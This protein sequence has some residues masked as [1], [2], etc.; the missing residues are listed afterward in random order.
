MAI[1]QLT[2]PIINPI[3]AFDA[4]RDNLVTFVVIGGTQVIANRLVI[5][6]NET[7]TIIYNK[8]K[9]TMKLEHTIPADTLGNGGY[10]NAVVYTI[11][12]AGNESD[13]STPVPFYCYSQP[14]LTISNIPTTETIG[15]GTYT[16]IGD[17]SQPEGEIL[18]SYQFTLYDSNKDILSQTPLIYYI[19]DSSLSYTFV[20]MSNDTA[21]Y[22]SISGET[23]NGT[24]ITSGL[25]YFTVRYLQPASFAICDLVNDCENGYIQISSNIVAIDGKSN[26]EPP[27]YIDDKE[28]DLRDPD[29]WVE[30]DEGFNIKDDFTMRVWGRDFNPYEN[31]ITLTNKENQN[32]SPN[33]IELKWMIGDIL[34]VLPEYVSVKGENVNVKNSEADS[35]KNLDIGGNSNQKTADEIDYGK[36]TS[37]TIVNDE[38]EEQGGKIKTI[39]HSEPLNINIYGNQYQF[40]QQGSSTEVEGESIYLSDVDAGKPADLIIKGNNYQET[41]EGY[42]LLDVNNNIASLSGLIYSDGIFT[43]ETITSQTV[44]NLWLRFKDTIAVN[45]TQNYYISFE[46]RIK[47]GTGDFSNNINDGTYSYTVV[48]KPTLSS[49]FQKYIVSHKYTESQE[50]SIKQILFQI[51]ENSNNLVIEIQNIMFGAKSEP[52]E[53]YGASPS[54]DYPSEVE[55]VGSNINLF[56]K[57][58]AIIING[59][60][61]DT[62]NQFVLSN[63]NNN[64]TIALKCKKDTTYTVSKKYGNRFNVFTYNELL[65]EEKTYSINNLVRGTNQ[66]STEPASQTI[67]TGD[68]EYLYVHIFDN[69][70]YFNLQNVL[71][72]IKIEEGSVATSYSPYNEGSVKI[73]VKNRNLLKIPFEKSGSS[74][75]LTWVVNDDGTIVLNGT[76]TASAHITANNVKINAK[77]G[78]TVTL[79]AKGLENIF[80]LGYKNIITGNDILTI[81]PSQPSNTITLTENDLQLANRLDVYIQSGKTFNNQTLKIMLEE[82]T[83]VTSYVESQEQ[84]FVM[85]IQ[86]EILKGDYINVD[87][88][89]ETHIMKKLVLQ[90]TETIDRWTVVGNTMTEWRFVISAKGILRTSSTTEI[91]NIICNKLKTTSAKNTYNKETG[92]SGEANS[93]VMIIYIEECKTMT[94]SEFNAYLKQQYDAGNPIIVYYQLATPISLPLTSEQ[95]EIQSQLTNVTLYQGVTNITNESSYP[96]IM[97]LNY[98][99]VREMPSPNY[100]SEIQTVGD[101]I[102]LL[103]D[104]LTLYQGNYDESGNFFEN[105]DR[106]IKDF[107]ELDAGQ[108]ILWSK[109]NNWI[110]VLIYNENKVLEKDLQSGANKKE[111]TFELVSKGYIRFAFYPIVDSLT[112]FK[113]EKGSVATP[114]SPYNQGSVEVNV[115]NKNLLN[116][117]DIEETEK[118]GVTYSIKNGVLTLNGTATVGIQLTFLR[119]IHIK[120]GKYTHSVNYIKNGLFFSF[121]NLAYTMLNGYLGNK[122]ITFE[123]TEDK[124]FS[125][126]FLFIS[127]NTVLDNVKLD[128][129]LEE[130]S[131][132]SDFVPHQSQSIIMPIQQ[133]MLTDDY[134]SGSEYHTWGKSILTGDENIGIDGVHQG[135][136]QFSV[137]VKSQYVYDN[138]IRALSNYFN[139]VGFINSWKVDNS[140]TT[141]VNGNIRFMTSK[142]AT[143]ADF[144]LFLK[145]KYDEGNPVVAYYKLATPTNISLTTEQKTIQNQLD[146][147]Y[148]YT[149][150][151]HINTDEGLAILKALTPA[152][153][154]PSRQSKIYSVGERKNLID[155]P[156]FNILLNDEYGTAT[157][158]NLVLKPN[159]TYTLSFDYDIHETST[160][161]YYSIG[162]GLNSY[163]QDIKANIVYQNITT[164]KNSAT[165]TVPND[166]PAN[167]YLWIKFGHT[168]IIANANVDIKNVQFEIGKTATKYQSPNLYNIYPTVS[169]KNLY[170]YNNP[171]YV[172]QNNISYNLIGGGYNI[173][174]TAVNQSASLILGI[175][176]IL[177]PGDTYAISFESS[178]QLSGYNLYITD[179]E[180]EEPTAEIIINNGVFTAPEG[181]YDLQLSFNVDSSSLDNFLEIWNIQIEANDVISEYETYGSNNS[182]IVLSEPI[183][184]LGERRDLICL[185][186]PNIINPETQSATVKGNT[187]Y[188]LSQKGSIK[189]YIWYY[190]EEGNLITFVDPEGQEASGAVGINGQFTT[191]K[192]CVK[193][194]ITKS[195]NPKAGDVNSDELISNQVIISKGSSEIPYYPYIT[196][197]SVI[198]YIKKVT[199]NGT[200]NWNLQ[201][202]NSYGI[203]NFNYKTGQSVVEVKFNVLSNYFKTQTTFVS[204]TAKEGIFMQWSNEFFIRIKSNRASTVD[205]FKSFLKSKYDKGNPV[206][207]YYILSEPVVEELSTDNISALQ[208]LKTYLP[209][210]NVFTNNNILATSSFDYV[211]GYT[212][213]QTENAY[214]L[215]K[216]WNSNTMPYVIHSNFIDIPKDINKVFIWMRRKN[217]IFDLKIEDLGDYGENDNPTDV[218]KPVV[219]IEINPDKVTSTQIPVTATSVDETGLRTVRFSK[220]N[221]ES[222]DEVIPV[223]GLSSINSYAFSNLNPNTVYP[224][225]VEAI[226]LAGNIGGIT[227]NVSTK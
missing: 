138:I 187:V 4:S 84:S 14:T 140:I 191:H 178:G 115:V 77:E 212:E 176:N 177:N 130:G 200:E 60:I 155:V 30:W 190:N 227:Q 148:T 37:I 157:K 78:A 31:I 109:N 33:K 93:D 183:R 202:I 11:D 136:T 135:I 29:S 154:S 54:P 216:C 98:N 82:G 108:Y 186:S 205:E 96:A 53:Q 32:G 174:P 175:K 129:Q 34:K 68:D 48:Q 215:L 24:K 105:N 74:N 111:V 83:T 147:S 211:D 188:Y 207:V 90:G 226:D 75:G 6:D 56:D 62:S 9:S 85:P 59:Y 12:S 142:Y 197:P 218:T 219:S 7:G 99:I 86:Q 113:L 121:D 195:N 210:S 66:E 162:Y 204:E 52:Y 44:R 58:N 220:N 50:K 19:T 119:N 198:R 153:P 8:T 159:Y 81:T 199:L 65:Q 122:T 22:I 125:T 150:I 51:K 158:T 91:A 221:G 144:K 21:Y 103:D 172:K 35:I 201:S 223:D 79:S 16:F 152:I 149:P 42:N 217:N 139:G 124:V 163:E 1:Q 67:S 184:G 127:Q 141:S 18:N 208:S 118:S 36:D 137:F 167:N 128:L 164:G 80:N 20:G 133:E 151:T 171:L 117:V 194:T 72:T 112:D 107:I 27:I 71:N 15:N 126:Y 206:E 222:W 214:V 193:I 160:D 2:Q 123:L 43:S 61:R 203:A 161:I 76:T 120:K 170:D 225:R 25:V 165:I 45:T 28:V 102:N 47:S 185:D 97:N 181:L 116:L 55:T 94:I 57:D 101:N 132:A 166:I 10:Y 70:N 5:S 131:T 95:Q 100:P 38:Q 114:Y 64:R 143:V 40:T 63:S 179:K 169:G 17:Y 196:K 180:S 110:H 39:P 189:Y 156:D 88:K 146:N 73:N 182:Q 87:N 89:Q 26:P 173:K 41:R 213:Q 106:A 49:S 23:V 13:A 168:T 134:I 145:S 3:A 104:N 209:I 69:I 92:I 224:I 46:A 192:D